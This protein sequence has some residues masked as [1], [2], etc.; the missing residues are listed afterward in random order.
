[1]PDR[2]VGTSGTV[3]YLGHAT[4]LIELSGVQLLTDPVLTGGVVTFIR[5]VSSAPGT[6]LGRTRVVLVSHGHHD[7]LHRASLRHLDRDVPVIVPVGL[8]ALVTRWGHREVVELPVGVTYDVGE[9]RVTAV[10]AD[11]SG[12]RPPLG[13][14]AAAVGY[15]I[16]DGDRRIYFAGDTDLYPGMADLAP[17][18]LDLALL[19]VWGWGPN[20]GAGHLDPER[21]ASAVALLAPR[22]AIPIHWGTLW[23]MALRWRRSRLVDPPARFADAVARL[24]PETRVVVLAPGEAL[25]LEMEAA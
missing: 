20:L 3:A 2:V 24:A 16:E 17:A 25:D 23:P 5:R 8:G 19:P 13:P 22:M 12:F 21:A 11:H 18:G 7:H 14:R 4:V 1:V 15:V 9:V 6:E 10:H